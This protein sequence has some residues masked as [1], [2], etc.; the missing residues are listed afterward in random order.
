[1][2]I[3]LNFVAM[4]LLFLN[5]AT[6]EE[7]KEPLS[8]SVYEDT[9][10]TITSAINTLVYEGVISKEF[11]IILNG[12]SEK[13]G[14]LWE[15]N[16]KWKVTGL[17]RI[18]LRPWYPEYTSTSQ[19]YNYPFSPPKPGEMLYQI[20]LHMT[21]KD[22]DGKV[23]QF[24]VIDSTSDEPVPFSAALVIEAEPPYR[25]IGKW[26]DHLQRW[27][28]IKTN[29]PEKNKFKRAPKLTPNLIKQEKPGKE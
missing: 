4:T 20:I 26:E 18:G 24:I 8:V 22:L 17:K 27:E 15:E 28:N 12:E 2:K 25:V 13:T 11:G 10:Y 23:R 3:L 9:V 1:M 14:K 7:Q 16:I 5:T 6:A 19:P 21:L 29:N